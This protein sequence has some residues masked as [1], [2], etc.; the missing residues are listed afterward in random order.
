M[1]EQATPG[2]PAPNVGP[3]AGAAPE[4]GSG[5][6]PPASV[7]G[8]LAEP[9]LASAGVGQGLGTPHSSSGRTPGVSF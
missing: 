3:A 7:G 4:L 2:M 1:P 8:R 6:T 5:Q 9:F